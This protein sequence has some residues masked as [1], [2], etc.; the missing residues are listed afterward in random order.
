MKL[1]EK[2]FISRT[3]VDGLQKT[4]SYENLVICRWH[5]SETDFNWVTI[6]KSRTLEKL[7]SPSMWL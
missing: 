1:K 6:I 7:L 2:S 4:K 3:K 5:S